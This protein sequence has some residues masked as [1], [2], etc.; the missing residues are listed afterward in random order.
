MKSIELNIRHLDGFV[1]EEELNAF[2]Q[3]MNVV[4]SMLIKRTGKGNDYLG[5]LDLPSSYKPEELEEIKNLAKSFSER[6]EIIVVVGIG[7]SYL[8][9]KALLETKKHTFSPLMG[10]SYNPELIFAGHQLSQD[11]LADL[12]DVLDNKEY[13]IIVISK[14]GTTTEPAVAFRILKKHLEEK[15]GIDSART[16]IIAITDKSRGALKQL[17]NEEG[18]PTFVV[19]DDV[20]GRYSVLSPVGLLPVAAAG[21]DIDK[22]LQGARDM[23]KIVKSSP[24]MN[25]NPAAKYAAIRNI[26]YRKGKA[27]EFLVNYLPSLHYF[28]EWWKQLFG[29]SEGKQNRGILPH[30]VSFTTDLHSMGQYMQDGLRVIFETTLS[31]EKT[32]RKINIPFDEAN[33]DGLNYLAGKDLQYVNHMAEMGTILAHVDGNVPNMQ[34]CVPEISAYYLGQLIYF[35]EASCAL[36]GYILD[37]NPFDQPGVEAYKNNMFA[38]LGKPG[39]EKATEEIKKRIR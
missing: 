14:S 9:A 34:I 28:T 37:V 8:G 3:E 4:H 18:Y 23:E 39:F 17:A 27:V 21:I 32:Q 31:V 11:Y 15:Y 33:L 7:G 26:L 5:W 29:E 12:L 38:L 22:L 2:Q 10:D 1:S 24:D 13:S 20:G 30:G 19:P 16:R 36:S 25:I 35:F 6:S